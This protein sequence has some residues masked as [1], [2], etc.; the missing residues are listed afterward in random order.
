MILNYFWVPKG[1]GAHKAHNWRVEGIFW[2]YSFHFLV[3]NNNGNR[4]WLQGKLKIWPNYPKLTGYMSWLKA[5]YNQKWW[6][7]TIFGSPKGRGFTKPTTGE[8]KAFFDFIVSIFW[9]TMTMKIEYDYRESSNMTK[10]Y[11]IGR[12]IQNTCLC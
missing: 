8:F 5:L 2:F 6:F 4:I 7:W 3:Y 12:R 11:Q 9:Y 10:L 1:A